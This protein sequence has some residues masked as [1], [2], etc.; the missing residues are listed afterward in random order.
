MPDYCL[1]SCCDKN[2]VMSSPASDG[3]E[4]FTVFRS[5]TSLLSISRGDVWLMQCMG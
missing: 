4:Q 2:S 5:G 3:H 1:I